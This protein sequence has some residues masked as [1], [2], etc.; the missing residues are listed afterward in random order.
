MQTG[1]IMIKTDLLNP[2]AQRAWKALLAK[3]PGP[4]EHFGTC[5]S[6][7]LEVAFP[8]PPG[9]NAGHLV[10][11]TARGKDLWLR[12][13]PPNMCYGVDDE[14]EMLDVIEQLLTEK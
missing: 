12:F 6:D 9:S 11:F 2:L 13:S 7:D 1:S 14:S 5:G 3:Y 4:E 8:A 10:A